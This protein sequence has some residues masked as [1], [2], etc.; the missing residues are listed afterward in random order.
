[1]NKNIQTL[2]EE[3]TTTTREYFDGRGN[4]TSTHFNTEKFAE[5]IIKKCMTIC[6]NIEYYDDKGLS[7]EHCGHIRAG[8]NFCRDDIKTHFGV[9]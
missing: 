4:V 8:A 5:L 1:M 9:E 6:K 7:P 2:I 3:S